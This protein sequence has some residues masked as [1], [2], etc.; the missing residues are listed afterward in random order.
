MTPRSVWRKPTLVLTAVLAGSLLSTFTLA[1]G[2]G[3]PGGPPP[4]GP[5]GFPGGPGMGRPGGGQ[6]TLADIPVSVLSTELKL[7]SDQ[8]T[9]IEAIQKKWRTQLQSMRPQFGPGGP[10]GPGGPPPGGP[11]GQDGQGGPPPV[12]P[13][14]QAGQDGQGGPPPGGPEGQGG[15]GGPGGPPPGGPGGF[16]GGPGGPNSKL[17]QLRQQT[18]KSIEAVLTDTQKQAVP[19]LLKTLDALQVSG[20]PIPVV[21]DL[22]LTAS[23]KTKIQNLAEATRQE[24][25]KAMDNARATGDFDS[26]REAL[27]KSHK[28]VHDK[29]MAILTTDQ[30]SVVSAFVKDHPQRG[31]GGFG[32]P[33]GGP[34]GDG[35]PPPP[36][37]QGDGPPP[38]L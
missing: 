15:P 16:P 18:I 28:S 21:S 31:P 9:K 7:T 4:G 10:G 22:K 38:N 29:V 35:P 5:G 17:F 25:R 13:H 19:G 14:L 1:Q 12:G 24:D 20:I 36:G 2:P 6:L 33:P 37:G 30:K 26:V 11:G 8:K 32:P 27:Q 3:G 23:Q 34:E